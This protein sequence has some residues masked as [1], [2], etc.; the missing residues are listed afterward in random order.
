MFEL[1]RLIK[2][3]NLNPFPD[4]LNTR[5]V[6]VTASIKSVCCLLEQVQKL[7]AASPHLLLEENSCFSP[8]KVPIKNLALEPFAKPQPQSVKEKDDSQK[9]NQNADYE[10]ESTRVAP[11]PAYNDGLNKA[12]GQPPRNGGPYSGST[13]PVPPPPSEN[14]SNPWCFQPP[15]HQWLVPVMSPSEGLIFKPYAGPCPPTAGFMPPVY[16]NYRP[17]SLPAGY[18]VPPHQQQNLSVLSGAPPMAPNYLPAAY[19]HPTMNPMISN[20]AVEQMSLMTGSRPD[21]QTEQN[22]RSSCNMSFPK[23]D[24]FTGRPLKVHAS[25]GSELQG[26]TASSPCERAQGEGRDALA[27]F[28]MAPAAETSVQPSESNGKEHQAN[29]MRVVP[30]N[31]R[32]ATESA[33]RIFRSIQEGR[34]QLDQ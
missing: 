14:R 1:H 7:L 21:L 26:S 30:H 20:S 29:V 17:M 11:L 31:G 6:C 24:A 16:G 32:S 18:G 3:S 25:K 33:A 10:T 23:S 9:P 5:N 19:G 15:A 34:Q 28:P 13:H 12:L 22:S 8:Q 2:V 4:T 27:L